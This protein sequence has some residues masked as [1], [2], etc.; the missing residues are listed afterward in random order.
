MNMKQ[1]YS[2]SKLWTLPMRYWN[3]YCKRYR[4]VVIA[5]ELYLWGIET[6]TC[7][8]IIRQCNSLNSTYEVL[9]RIK[10]FPKI[11]NFL[12]LNSTYEVLKHPIILDISHILLYLWTLPMRYWNSFRSQAIFIP[13]TL[14]TLPMRYWNMGLTVH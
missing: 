3:R 13:S 5:F 1:I 12:P 14:W 7:V 11:L 10:L 2:K 4:V 8:F 6:N 9:K